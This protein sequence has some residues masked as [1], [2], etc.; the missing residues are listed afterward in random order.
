LLVSL[1]A[2]LVG[3]R[4]LRLK[5]PGASWRTGDDQSGTWKWR[6]SDGEEGKRHLLGRKK[7]SISGFLLI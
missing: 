3:D 4:D 5:R 6:G 2:W 7:K 1:V